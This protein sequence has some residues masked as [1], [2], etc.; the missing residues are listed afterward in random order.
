VPDILRL[1]QSAVLEKVGPKAA[2]GFAYNPTIEETQLTAERNKIY[3]CI[4]H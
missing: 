4:F 1:C 2:T 3:V